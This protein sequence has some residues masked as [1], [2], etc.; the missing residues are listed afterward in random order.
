MISS[1]L[2]LILKMKK[3][4]K[5]DLFSFLSVSCLPYVLFLLTLPYVHYLLGED[6][7]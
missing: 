1:I 3:K 2:A 4:E 5:A 7:P 6:S